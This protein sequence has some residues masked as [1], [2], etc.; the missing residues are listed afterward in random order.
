[1]R[2]AVLVAWSLI[3]SSA[4]AG[5]AHGGS[6]PV[7]AAASARKTAGPANHPPSVRARCAP[8]TLHVGETST[9]S[10][11]ATDPDRDTLTYAW[12]APGGALR[13]GSARETTWTAPMSDGAVPV[14]VRVE[15][16]KG[17]SASDVITIQVLAKA[18]SSARP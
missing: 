8:C 9:L 13:A 7:S 16:G 5:C 10:A 12:H 11:D 18:P 14:S 1:L 4:F 6:R 15:D 3:L 2:R 17:G